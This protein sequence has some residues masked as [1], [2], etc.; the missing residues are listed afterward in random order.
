MEDIRLVS[1]S[2]L[3]RISR[4]FTG[5]A[6]LHLSS[7]SHPF[8]MT[9]LETYIQSSD[10][11]PSP[12]SFSAIKKPVILTGKFSL[13]P[14]D[15]GRCRG[16]QNHCLSFSDGPSRVCCYVLDF[17]PNVLGREIHVLAW[18]F[19]PLKDGADGGVLEVIRWCFSG[20]EVVSDREFLLSMP[21]TSSSQ[22]THSISCGR[23]YG[24]LSSVSS[25]FNVPRAAQSRGNQKKSH[26]NIVHGGDSVG[27]LAEILSCECDI[28]RNYSSHVG[29]DGVH[30]FTKS[31]FVYFLK[32]TS[33]WRPLLC[34]LVGGLILVSGL[35]KKLVFVG[36]EESYAMF[37]STTKTT[38][39]LY[40]LL[41]QS[42]PSAGMVEKARNNERVYTGVVVGIY[43]KGAVIELDKNVWLLVDDTQV[44]PQH[45]IRVGAIVSVTNFHLVRPK[46]AWTRIVLLGTCVKTNIVIKSFS[47]SNTKCHT[48]TQRTSLLGK[49]IESLTLSVRF[50]VLLLISCFK[51]KF[52]MFLSDKEILGSRH[53][54]GLAQIY[55]TRYLSSDAF[56]CQQGMFMKFCKHDRCTYDAGSSLTPLKLVIPLSNFVSKCEEIWVSM[57]PKIQEDA[58][59]LGDTNT[60]N[61]FFCE[62]TS[63][64]SVIRRLIP[65]E[66]LGFILMGRI[67]T[68]SSSGRLQLVDATGSLDV[69]IPDLLSNINEQSVYEVRDYKLVLEGLPTQ[70]ENLR[71][72]F[73]QPLSCR[74]IF[75]QFA[76]RKQLDE[77]AVYAHFYLRDSNCLHVPSSIPSHLANTKSNGG[78]LFHLLRITHKFPASDDFQDDPSP[79]MSKSSSLFAEASVFPYD[80]L[81]PDKS[82]Y[83]QLVGA[84]QDK[85]DASSDFMYRQKDQ[86]IKSSTSEEFV[87]LSSRVFPT[88]LI[89][90]LKARER[91]FCHIPC[92]LTYKNTNFRGTLVP[93]SLCQSDDNA[94]RDSVDN[95]P[96]SIILLEFNS[97]NFIRYQLLRIG[98]YYLVKCS[99]EGLPCNQRKCECLQCSKALVIS[100]DSLWSFSTSVS[101]NNNQKES[102]ENHSSGVS[103]VRISGNSSRKCCQNELILLHPLNHFHENS[104]FHLSLFCEAVVSVKEKVLQHA[105]ARL[106]PFPSEVLSTS[107]CVQLMMAELP[108]PAVLRG[109]RLAQGD[110]ISLNGNIEHIHLINC[111][112]RSFMSPKCLAESGKR[113]PNFCI[114]V[115]DDN[116]M[117]QIRG[118]LSKHA[119]PIGIGAGVRATFHRVLITWSSSRR[120][121]LLLTP[122]TFIEIHSTKEV[123]NQKKEKRT[124]Q[125][126]RFHSLNKA[127]SYK[128]SLGL[129]S[130]LMRC[131]DDKLIRFHCR[132]VMPCKLVLENYVHGSINVE[133]GG[134]C[135]V[136][137]V[138]IPIAGFVLDDGSSLCCCWAAGDQAETLLKLQ[139]SACKYLFSNH[140]VSRGESSGNLKHSV[141][142][143]LEKMLKR[144][145]KVIIKNYGITP[146][147]DSDKV[148]SNSEERLLKFII[149]KACQGPVFNILG[150]P[151]DSD[152]LRSLDADLLE[153]N[154]AMQP[155]Q[156]LWV[157]EV[158]YINVLEEA[159]NMLQNMRTR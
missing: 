158:A 98:G 118:H 145:Q 67:K 126:S 125:A 32:P 53:K 128:V 141:G 75:Q 88:D 84:F 87:L 21:S 3:L 22:E 30:S 146:S 35:K 68:S 120:H 62:T 9:D 54:E 111:K 61:H 6:S 42:L 12:S 93:G 103:S 47:L 100:R 14:E 29:G 41:V 136:L 60:F 115:A 149:L 69:V 156:N 112:S 25:V 74:S 70:L 133:P 71:Y 97:A 59:E 148:L 76:F 108:M 33:L 36:G 24:V 82:E 109:C 23:A 90:N 40:P 27:F 107:S 121:E 147:Y 31:V 49:F 94:L 72:H 114:H 144:H 124:M 43:M 116:C 8:K 134:Q 77:I 154:A 113:T 5:A 127:S 37:V 17:D 92:S 110:L 119:Y 57:L 131:M 106:V 79:T 20:R 46:F 48:K 10:R 85:L 50:W 7:S 130:Q 143:H 83:N 117:V 45:S 102:S 56:K 86:E 157:K 34:K 55:A 16:C 89:R 18:N 139:E 51:E 13:L 123:V 137:K 122:V 52:G 66:N 19:V 152:A 58:K 15:S 91:R 28:C 65:S 11:N 142:H 101:E 104:D 138:K 95:Q 63:Y 132:V 99:S 73:G 153:F 38:A 105:L 129:F 135:R 26:A 1:L 64:P 151:L 155:M 39:S 150:S 96:A 44:L 80:L 140:K 4:P 159:R 78:G 2:D 81:F